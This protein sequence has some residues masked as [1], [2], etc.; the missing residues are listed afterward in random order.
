[1]IRICW[2]KH[3]FST[4]QWWINK[5]DCLN[6]GYNSLS[7]TSK[8][9]TSGIS[10]SPIRTPI[11]QIKTLNL[12]KFKKIYFSIISLT[13]WTSINWGR[14]LNLMAESAGFIFILLSPLKTNSSF[15]SPTKRRIFHFQQCSLNIIKH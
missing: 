5:C 13:S 10:F 11:K 12:F 8:G 9:D 7:V 4:S 3:L 14:S 15:D 2:K 6:C 1:M